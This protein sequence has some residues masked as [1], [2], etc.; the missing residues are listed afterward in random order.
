ME[1]K[2]NSRPWERRAGPTHLTCGVRERNI[3]TQN[4]VRLSLSDPLLISLSL[5]LSFSLQF[6]YKCPPCPLFPSFLSPLT[7]FFFSSPSL[8]FPPLPPLSPAHECSDGLFQLY[9]FK[10]Q[11]NMSFCRQRLCCENRERCIICVS[12][13]FTVTS[14]K[15]A[16][17]EL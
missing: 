16:G 12:K 4:A 14:H 6:P 8:S 11:Q 13:R 5:P 15:G 9:L 2:A 3:Q 7:C 17:A 10:P 1:R